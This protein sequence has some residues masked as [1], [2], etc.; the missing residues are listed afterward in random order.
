MNTLDEVGAHWRVAL[1]AAQDALTA[2][3][4]C[5]RS[6]GWSAGE[7]AVLERRLS[8]ERVRTERLLDAVAREEHVHLSRRLITPRATVHTLGLPHGTRACLF[9]LDGVLAGSAE[10][11]AAAW[12]ESINDLLSRRLERAGE[13]FGPYRPFSARSDYDRYLHGR[14]RLS[15]AH[16]FLPEGDPD[17]PPGAETVFGLGNRKN[18]AVQRLLESEGVRAFGGSVSYL[19]AAR[20]A[21]MRCAVLSVSANTESILLHAGLAPLVDQIV[22]GNVIR[23]RDLEPKPAPDTILTACELLRV[24]P[25]EAAIFETTI[26]G[27]EAGRA[28]RVGLA[29]AVDRSGR[30][31]PLRA[32]GAGVVVGDLAELLAA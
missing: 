31:E 18:E 10:L 7:L 11:H 6:A 2:V 24:E 1:F 30:A 13:R 25:G 15:G 17:D 16:A 29:V 5:G 32:H 4:A 12:R 27:L 23:K 26:E 9:D 28:A 21:G 22:D 3:R 14:P 20:E 19:E 8:E